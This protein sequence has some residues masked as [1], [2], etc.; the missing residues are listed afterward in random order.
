[1]IGWFILLMIASAVC[2]GVVGYSLSN[3]DGN[4]NIAWVAAELAFCVG[5][6]ALAWAL[7]TVLHYEYPENLDFWD[8]GEITTQGSGFILVLLGACINVASGLVSVVRLGVAELKDGI[9][10]DN[11]K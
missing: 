6:F 3:E 9:K 5:C 8:Y 1:M 4:R 10:A 2:T 7:F 11:S